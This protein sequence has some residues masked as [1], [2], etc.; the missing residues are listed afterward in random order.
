M[1]RRRFRRIR[2]RRLRFL[3]GFVLV[4]GLLVVVIIARSLLTILMR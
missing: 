4:V 2:R 1:S 3:V